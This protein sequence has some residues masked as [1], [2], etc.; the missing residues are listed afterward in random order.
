MFN[1]SNRSRKKRLAADTAMIEPGAAKKK[2]KSTPTENLAESFASYVKVKQ[3][4]ASN[5]NVQQLIGEDFKDIMK[6]HSLKEK[7]DVY[8]RKLQRYTN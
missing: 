4:E 7:I 5:F 6:S 2:R 3:D 8:E 1:S